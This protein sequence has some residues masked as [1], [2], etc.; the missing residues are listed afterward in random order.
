[1]FVELASEVPYSEQELFVLPAEFLGLI[2]LVSTLKL[3]PQAR[4]S[5]E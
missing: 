2:A 5:V 1:M 4:N 3:L